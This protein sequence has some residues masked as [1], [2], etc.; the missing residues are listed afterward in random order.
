[1]AA[2]SGGSALARAQGVLA[3]RRAE[4]ICVGM[5]PFLMLWGLTLCQKTSK[6]L[7]SQNKKR[8]RPTGREPTYAHCG[9]IGE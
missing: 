1:V 7:S 2:S 6:E 9:H 8:D 4:G 5:N 3:W